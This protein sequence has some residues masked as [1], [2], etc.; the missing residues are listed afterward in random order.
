MGLTEIAC[1]VMSALVLLLY[2]CSLAF[3]LRTLWSRLQTGEQDRISLRETGEPD[4][5]E[6]ARLFLILLA[7]VVLS[8]VLQYLIGHMM[9][10]GL[11]HTVPLVA[12]RRA[13]L[14]GHCG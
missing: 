9:V 13:A 14:S 11:E 5:R 3:A 4:T 10:Y 2:A 1:A 12:E 6:S 8:R 7:V